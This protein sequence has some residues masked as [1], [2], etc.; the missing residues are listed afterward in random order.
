MQK[1]GDKTQFLF[2]CI[3]LFMYINFFCSINSLFLV[4]ESLLTLNEIVLIIFFVTKILSQK[5]KKYELIYLLIFCFLFL[6]VALLTKQK[7][8]LLIALL[9]FSMK[10]TD[11][12]KNLKFSFITKTVVI[13]LLFLI[14]IISGILKMNGVSFIN[15]SDTRYDMFLTHPNFASFLVFW[16]I[17]D[18]V[19]LKRENL[20]IKNYFVFTI[21]FI[22]TYIFTKSRTGLIV[23]VLLIISLLFYP[24]INDKKFISKFMKS[25]AKNSLLLFYIIILFL[26]I[27]SSSLG[28]KNSLYILLDDIFSRRLSLSIVAYNMYGFSFLP[29]F[30]D[31]KQLIT[32]MYNYQTYRMPLAIDVFY[33]K[34]IVSY[35]IIPI[36]MISDV[37]KK[38][39]KKYND[40]FCILL[41]V[42]FSIYGLS[43]S[44]VFNCC[45][46]P[47]F[48]I[49]GNFICNG[50]ENNEK[51]SISNSSNL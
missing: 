43:E 23:N 42:F 39:L 51:E 6:I 48:F 44:L 29:R 19:L 12:K 20:N 14:F 38:Y 31:T 45:S 17:F 11:L 18:Y 1:A 25:F 9:M 3:L 7:S 2:Y 50:G 35:S 24:K 28:S 37:I 40:K 26:L 47:I 21:I 33:V 46:T 22:V 27:K 34:C 15:F 10:N 16:T 49:L 4:P 41:F 30:V 32:Y 8:I 36:I 5:Y 13:S